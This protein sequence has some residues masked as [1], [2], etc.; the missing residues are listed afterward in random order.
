MLLSLLLDT[1]CGHK[2][3]DSYARGRKN[4]F[5]VKAHCYNLPVCLDC[6][7]LC[8]PLWSRGDHAF[9]LPSL[10]CQLSGQ[11]ALCALCVV[12][13]SSCGHSVLYSH[14]TLWSKCQMVSLVRRVFVWEREVSPAETHAA[15]EANIA[16]VVT[17]V[18]HIYCVTAMGWDSV[19]DCAAV[20]NRCRFLGTGKKGRIEGVSLLQVK[21]QFECMEFFYGTHGRQVG[22]LWVMIWDRWVKGVSC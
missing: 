3:L 12:Q 22:S 20:E 18:T 21:E 16:C 7:F 14:L 15:W 6:L 5:V 13:Q 9:P 1:L 10:F 17:V 4:S 19:K 11:G 8:V 2:L